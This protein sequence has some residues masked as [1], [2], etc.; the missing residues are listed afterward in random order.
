MTSVDVT[1]NREGLGGI[2]TTIPVCRKS[3]GRQASQE[4]RA[5]FRTSSAETATSL[6]RSA[7][8][9]ARSCS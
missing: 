9:S 6:R 3:R 4:S 1:D 8:A 2:V 5:A 7:R